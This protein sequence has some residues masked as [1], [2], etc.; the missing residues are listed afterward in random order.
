MRKIYYLCGLFVAAM[1]FTGC[2][3]NEEHFPGFEDEKL[4]KDVVNYE[5][6][7]T[8]KYPEAGYF[9]LTVGSNDYT[10]IEKAVTSMLDGMYPYCDEG[11]TARVTIKVADILPSYE[12]EPDASVEYELTDTDYESM[13]TG[14]GE[15]GEHHNFSSS[16]KPADYLPEFCKN[17]Y[18]DAAAGT[19][20]KIVYKFYSGSVAVEY[21]YYQKQNNGS[22]K[23]A[24][25]TFTADKNYTMSVADYR[26]IYA[27][28]NAYRFET[29]A[30]DDVNKLMAAFLK[31]KY[32]Y[33]VYD[34]MTVR[35]T[36]TMQSN[37]D[38][39]KDYTT[40]SVYRYEER[41]G[42]WSYYKTSDD[43]MLAPFDRIGTFKFTEGK[44]MLDAF[45]NGVI[46]LAMA[47]EDYTTLYEWVKANKPEFLSTQNKPEEYYFGA[48]SQYGNINN[49]Y[50]TWKSFYNV[51]GY[52]NGLS[53][54]QIQEIMDKRLAEEGI[55]TLL[56]P[57]MVSNPDASYLYEVVYKIYAGRGDGNYSMTFQ[58][59]EVEGVNKFV[60]NGATPVK[61]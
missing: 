41:T 37:K 39:S 18:A 42:L 33:V 44:W 56:L 3:Y 7:F 45:I 27:D 11:S 43:L 2:D 55:A 59:K 58:Y 31:N 61:Q 19:I 5:G 14:K 13:G 16:C 17:K 26:A 6:E 10:E 20:V 23:E 46:K 15:P 36:Y 48:S 34:G 47:A 35:V 54:A 1:T 21:R 4:S 52:L 49:K 30:Y 8:G 28:E 25:N 53:D 22:W 60:W 12:E 51:D 50:S 9:T 29:A 24:K 38:T 40:N 32:A 57:S